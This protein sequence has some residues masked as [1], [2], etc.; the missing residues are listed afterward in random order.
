MICFVGTE[1]IGG[2]TAD[3]SLTGGPANERLVG[4]AG[5]DTIDAS[6]GVDTLLGQNGADLLTA[7]DGIADAATQCG[8][9]SADRTPGDRA[10]A[11]EAD[12]VDPSCV[13]I[14]R[15]GAGTAGPVGTPPSD[16]PDAPPEFQ[17]TP[18]ETI[19]PDVPTSSSDGPNPGGGN[20]GVTPP[21]IQITSPGATVRKGVAELRVLCV[22]RAENCVGDVELIARKGAKAGKGRK[23]IVI[24]KGDEL[25][26]QAVE[27]P[28]GTSEP[29][30]VE[31]T[32]D[33]RK[34]FKAGRDSIS[35][36]AT[37][38]AR[39]GGA[40]ASAAAAEV[41]APVKLGAAGR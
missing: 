1:R 22:Y 9:R 21:E 31:V 4:S 7:R 39:D 8:Q 27:M 28:W 35:A 33:V 6:A 26:S 14:E 15:G 2:S 17:P 25:G 18:T 19:T 13:V 32:R 30:R 41:S 37:V 40:G 20:G 3:D 23:Q 5:N 36:T 34:L 16:E 38:T 29:V 11:D 10:V 24:A 12:P